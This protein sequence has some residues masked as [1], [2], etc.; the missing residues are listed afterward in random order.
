VCFQFPIHWPGAR[1]NIDDS[2]HD[3]EVVQNCLQNA[4]KSKM[5]CK[6]KFNLP[7]SV[8]C[9]RKSFNSDDRDLAAR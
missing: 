3:T 1:T 5:I 2:R 4:N 7:A 9:G 8:H 6:Y